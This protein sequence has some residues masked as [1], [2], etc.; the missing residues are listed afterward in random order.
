M[1]NAVS[2]RVKML[3]FAKIR[4]AVSNFEFETARKIISWG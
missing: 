1:L 3:L 2:F 4:R